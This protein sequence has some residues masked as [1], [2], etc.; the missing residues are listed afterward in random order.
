MK[1]IHETLLMICLLIQFVYIIK[2]ATKVR[3]SKSDTYN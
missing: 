1:Y 2:R 3:R